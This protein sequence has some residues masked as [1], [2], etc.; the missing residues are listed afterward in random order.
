M[1]KRFTAITRRG[2]LLSLFVLGLVA[3]IIL[4]PSQ[5]TSEAG[6]QKTMKKGLFERTESHEEGLDWYDIREDKTA[7]V[8]D[9]IMQF[10][11]TVGR[12]AVAIADVRDKFVKGENQLR[13]Q[14]PT[15]KVEY[16]TD[17]RIPE[18]ITPD[19]WKSKAEFL[20]RPTQ[21]N[22]AQVLRDF[23][24]QN[25]ELVGVSNRQVDLLKTTADYTNPNGDLSYAMLEQFINDVPV[26]RG[27]VKAGFTK[28]GEMVRVINNLAPGLEYSSLST[29]F[30]EP[31]DAVKA[32]ASHINY[33][34]LSPDVT[35]NDAES[36]DLKVVYGTGTNATTAEKMY[37]PTEPGVAIPAWRVLIWK[38]VQAYY[39]IVSAE[40]GTMLWRKNITDDQTQSATYSVYVNPNAMINVADSPAP[41]TP[42]PNAPGTQ[43]G[44]IT[45]RTSMT[46]IGNEGVYSFNNNGWITD[47]TNITD[48]NNV[49]AGVDRVAP[50]GV[51]APATGSPN[52]VF[53]NAWNPPPGN[54]APGDDPLTPVAQYGATTSMFYI[55]NRYHDEM[56]RLGFNE[57]AKNFQTTNFTAQG[58]GNDRISAEGQDSSGT[59]N[60]N[61]ST[62]ADGG[63]GI[64]QMYLWTG[65]TPDYDGTTDAEVII[66]ES[67]HGTSNR[68]HGNGS[69]LGGM[70]GMMGEGWSD[71]YGHVMLSEP[72]DDINGVYTTG[73]YATYQLG[74]FS[75]NYFYGIRRFPKALLSVTGGPAR[76]AC[77]NAPCPINPFTFKHV[78]AD[79][80][81]T[82]G[83]TTTAVS[84]AFP[85][86]PV[87]ATS[88]SCNQVHNAGEIWSSALWEVRGLMLTRLGWAVGNR[89]T[90]QLVTDGMKLAP[91]NPTFLQERDAIIAAAAA[92]S[93]APEASADVSDV[94]E[95]FRRRGMGFSASVQSISAV[96]EAFDSP[97]AIISNPFSVSD[98]TGDGDGFPEPGEN[99]LISVPISNTSGATINNVNGSITG[100]GTASYGNIA[101]GATVVRQITYTVPAGATCGALQTVNITGTSA[102]G[103]LNPQTF[104]FRLGAP[105]GG[106]PAVFTSS[107][108]ITIPGTGTGPGASAPY[109]TT[110]TAS[111]LTGNKNIRLEL[112][113]L[114]HT[115]PGDIDVLLV[116]PG[117]QKFIPLSDMGGTTDIVSGNVQLVDTATASLPTGD[118]T[119]IGEFKPGDNTAGDTFTA[120]APVAPYTSPAPVGTATFASTFGTTGSGLNG[121]WTLYV[122]DD[123]GVDSG[124]MTGWKLT[125]ESN[126]Y[127]CALNTVP[128]SRADFD[129]DGK[130]DLSVF[131]PSEGNWYLNRSTAG[132]TVLNWGLSTDRLVPGDYDGDGKADVAVF[133]PSNTAGVSDFYILKSSDSTLQGA[134]WGIVGDVPV[135]GNFDGD[136][137]DDI[138]IFRPS[139]GTWYI[140][141]S[142]N[143]TNT[144]EPFG[145]NGDIPVTMDSDN[146]GK[147]NL[148]VYRPSNLTWYVARNSGTPAANFDAFP[149]GL[150]GDKLVPG[151]YDNDNKTDVAVYRPSTGTW[152]I[153]K[154][155]DGTTLNVPFGIST[156]I[157]VPGDY[158]GDG[159]D[160]I[161][162]YRNGT[163]YINRSTSGMLIQAFGVSTDTAIPKAYIP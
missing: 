40:D 33:E 65:P 78:N 28:N 88:G 51:D 129:G 18:V 105:V 72:T 80:D 37:F 16:N 71:F 91:L 122:M 26:F 34:L 116:G 142:S 159:T 115:F 13:T 123:A 74:G 135:S 92:S 102:A 82:L 97:N 145:L 38:P 157:P 31:L 84:S 112:T 35:R 76:P 85:R 96:T 136:T 8:A 113:G 106:A 75:A 124:S 140:L 125:F 109:G 6:S 95:G 117:G 118:G 47:G 67:T 64:M 24:K 62:P 107:T 128:K 68:L 54:P 57:A 154:S 59:N 132:F 104:S 151:D 14:V 98:S 120:P 86:S 160:D 134:E 131:R 137:K 46:L 81:T 30:R 141:N 114:T 79:C 55:E 138:A 143:G 158:D 83:T 93:A 111:G 5:F 156:D 144:I 15:L 61:F 103:A 101:D 50:S 12:D 53:S 100:G 3:A 149:F 147:T 10:R 7:G 73:G 66:H 25:N 56:Y 152:I 27:E 90:L 153:R 99:V 119:I 19:V 126:D 150:A 43:Q 44:A 4:V 20:T 58:V 2:L 162:V 108:A 89:K 87:I 110:I 161:A 52:R 21:E 23:I 11:Q 70:G 1:Q 32:A 121:V 9:K 133:R 39:V 139:S 17:I 29:N 49:E 94:R 155:T 77:G 42:G 146:D 36:S 41:L 163:W 69:G 22:R 45:A 48:G 148:A 127:V 130:T 63:R 60:A